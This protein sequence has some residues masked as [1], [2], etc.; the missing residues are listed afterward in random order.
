M[1]GTGTTGDFF[2]TDGLTQKGFVS[3]NIDNSSNSGSN[4]GVYTTMAGGSQSNALSYDT[5]SKWAPRENILASAKILAIEGS[6]ILGGGSLDTSL[7]N[8]SLIV[9]DNPE[10]FSAEGDDDYIIFRFRRGAENQARLVMEPNNADGTGKFP[11]SEHRRTLDA[12]HNTAYALGFHTTLKL[13]TVKQPIQANTIALACFNSGSSTARDS[14]ITK[15][16]DGTTDLCVETNLSE[17]YISPKKY[18]ITMCFLNTDS[19]SKRS[20]ESICN[21]NSN[22]NEDVDSTFPQLGS[23]YNE[24]TYSYNAA[25]QTTK[26]A[27]ALTNNPWI[28]EAGGETTSLD[29]QDYGHGGFDSDK[30]TGGQAG[31]LPILNNRLNTMNISGIVA[32]GGMMGGMP[33]MGGG[34]PSDKPIV[35]VLG[36]SNLT[37]SKKVVIY[38]DDFDSQVTAFN[39]D[40][41]KAMNPQYIWQYTSPLPTVTDFAVSPVFDALEKDVNLYELEKEN[42]NAVN[43]TWT[44][45]GDIWYRMLMVDDV[46]IRNKYHKAKLWIPLNESPNDITPTTKTTLN[47]Y[48]DPSSA[49]WGTAQS[50]T[51][52]VGA[53]VLQDIQGL[54]GYA[55]RIVSG[56]ESHAPQPE[57]YVFIPAANN[58]GLKDLDEYTFVMHVIPD[59]QASNRDSVCLFS[60][61]SGNS[62][63]NGFDIYINTDEKIVV[64]QDGA[65]LTGTSVIPTDGETP[66]SI[67][68]TYRKDS[69]TDGL[70]P[71]LRLYI[72]G[73]IED[74]VVTALGNVTT[75]ASDIRVGANFDDTSAQATTLYKGL[76]EEVIIYEKRWEIVE[77]SGLYLYN[78]SPLADVNAADKYTPHNARLFLYDHHNIRGKN[79]DEVCGSDQVTWKVTA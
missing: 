76:V 39:F 47:W 12:P 20:Y 59:D 34:A 67:V 74:Y 61:G 40:S 37:A 41:I 69:N 46:P 79:R 16:D 54:Q 35:L 71:D 53:E 55:S 21:I 60:Q 3:V 45:S 2:S 17:L 44:E 6:P 72:N 38:G 4:S 27:A 33:G 43:F 9:V 51:C 15:A 13:A 63:G 56:S 48:V 58:S 23:T 32:G 29:L 31:V 50:G 25:D 8:S 73:R 78:T 42:L 22:P 65:F 11:D 57:G 26:G 70:G 19:A 49:Y 10:I 7:E 24:F 75:T 77:D 1:F 66:T 5:Y 52:T 18:W 68:V 62:V 14:G 64:S 36:L 30:D 28:L